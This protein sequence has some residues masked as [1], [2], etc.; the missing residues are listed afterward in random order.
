MSD[1]IKLDAEILSMLSPE[2][3]D[4]ACMSCITDLEGVLKR[5]FG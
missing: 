4:R 3:L 2:E 5:R 1:L